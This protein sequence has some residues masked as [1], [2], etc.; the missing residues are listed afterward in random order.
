MP[1]VVHR[2]HHRGPHHSSSPMI[3]NEQLDSL[4]IVRQS[5]TLRTAILLY[6]GRGT[7]SPSIQRGSPSSSGAKRCCH[8]WSCARSPLSA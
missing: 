6:C 5:I 1:V 7:H 2:V 3:T 8:H 4:G